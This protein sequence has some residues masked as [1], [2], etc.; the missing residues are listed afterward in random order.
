M[1]LAL[2]RQI[3]HKNG[4]TPPA[5]NIFSTFVLLTDLFC[6]SISCEIIIA[7]MEGVSGSVQIAEL[8][9]SFLARRPTFPSLSLQ[10]KLMKLSFNPTYSRLVCGWDG[11]YRKRHYFLFF[12][13]LNIN[14]PNSNIAS[15]T[16]YNLF[17]LLGDIYYILLRM[18]KFFHKILRY[19]TFLFPSLVLRKTYWSNNIL[20]VVFKT[21]AFVL[22]PHPGKLLRLCLPTLTFPTW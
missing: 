10:L 4:I 2:S 19:F 14:N 22:A 15:F 18:K 12:V 6:S 3:L 9:W 16:F 17:F 7:L 5:K 20:P 21:C 1:Y 13:T 8:K 11:I